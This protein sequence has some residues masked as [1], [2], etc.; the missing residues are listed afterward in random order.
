M[1]KLLF[2]ALLLS[3]IS[4]CKKDYDKIDQER[5][6]TYLKD[7]GLT[8][9]K[10]ASGVYFI[11]EKEGIGA[12]PV[13]SSEVAVKYKGYTLD[14]KEFDKGDS[15]V[16]N[17]SR[18]I[19][20]WQDGI[21]EFKKGGSGKIL[22]PSSLGYGST[23]AGNIGS[24]EPLVFD[25]KL[26]GIDVTEGG[27]KAELKAYAA[28]KGWV[29]DSLP[30]GLFYVIEKQGTGGNPTINS[31]VTVTYKGYTSDDKI[32]DGS[33]GTFSLSNVIKGWQQG[34]PLFKKGG[35]GRLLI[36]SKLAYGTQG[37]GSIKPRQPIIFDVELI[38][39]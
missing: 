3:T 7:K 10:T 30:S 29:L 22:I 23:G 6:E 39:F 12:N 11:I 37:S 20:G 38:D 34:I 26:L 33:T 35:K 1:K 16:T 32:F 2:F 13:A 25:I 19:L 14:D 18:T 5:I 28:K 24:N 8:A 9:Q 21:K 4:A 27:N 36:P 17:L 31:T 15:L